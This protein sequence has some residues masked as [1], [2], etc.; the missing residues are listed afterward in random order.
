MQEVVEVPT[1]EDASSKPFPYPLPL[2]PNT[3][4]LASIPLALFYPGVLA[5]AAAAGFTGS[6]VG[7][8]LPGGLLFLWKVDSSPSPKQKPMIVCSKHLIQSAKAVNNFIGVVD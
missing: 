5:L 6:T 8:G 4:A 2:D 7:K 3:R 1:T